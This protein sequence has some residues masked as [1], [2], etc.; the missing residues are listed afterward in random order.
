MIN[1]NELFLY[2]LWKMYISNVHGASD[3]GQWMIMI[4]IFIG[5]FL[6]VAT[7]YKLLKRKSA[8]EK[9]IC[10]AIPFVLIATVSIM[11]IVIFA[12]FCSENHQISAKMGWF[13]HNDDFFKE[14][15]GLCGMFL[16]CSIFFTL[17]SRRAAKT[18]VISLI[19][20]QVVEYVVIGVVCWCSY[21]YLNKNGNFFFELSETMI[22]WYIYGLWIL[23]RQ[24]A[25]YLLYIICFV[26]FYERRREY[27]SENYASPGDWLARY[28]SDNY[29]GPGVS[30]LAYGLLF[31]WITAMLFEEGK[32]IQESFYT[33]CITAIAAAVI[34]FCGFLML[35]FS[36]F[37]KLLGSYKMLDKGQNTELMVT[38]I[39][40]ELETEEPLTKFELGRGFI[41]KNFIVLYLPLR[42]YYIPFY[43]EQR[44]CCF[45]FSDGRKF[46][47]NQNDAVTVSNYLNR[48]AIKENEKI[49][50]K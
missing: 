32:R 42:I 16:I 19:F 15:L 2:K 36:I 11:E 28:L 40:R 25:F 37:P 48:A 6:P 21:D 41:T 4:Q 43:Q 1:L 17:L 22:K 34:T 39:Y 44:G 20:N 27:V 3:T 35:F 8:V 18:S 38:Q 10:C 47:I 12:V 7:L 23:F 13:L 46:F 50:Y 5:I 9:L 26:L 14:S 45:Y 49:L 24:S 30:I 29:R 31:V 33:G